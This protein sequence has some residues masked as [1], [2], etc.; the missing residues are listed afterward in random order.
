M[1]GP[2]TVVV[3]YPSSAFFVKRPRLDEAL[4][5]R[6]GG[7][8]YW[9][10]LSG[11]SNV[12]ARK[13]NLIVEVHPMQRPRR[14]SVD[15]NPTALPSESMNTDSTVLIHPDLQQFSF[16]KSTDHR[17]DVGPVQISRSQAEQILAQPTIKAGVAGDQLQSCQGLVD[18]RRHPLTTCELLEMLDFAY[19][20]DLKV[21]LCLQHGIILPL[22][23][24]V[25][26][27]K[28]HRN[29]KFQHLTTRLW[30]EFLAHVRCVF[31]GLALTSDERESIASC[32]RI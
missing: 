5:Q 27:A 7:T 18:A 29:K 17:F 16:G 8:E 20:P 3:D 25:K 14:Q 9:H 19:R 26:H 12:P 15:G 23:S 13:E 11:L 4:A 22:N 32:G 1:A 10:H 28:K 21:I 6:S 2:P 31:D 30:E 24:L